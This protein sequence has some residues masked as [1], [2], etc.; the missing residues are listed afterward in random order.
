[1]VNTKFGELPKEA[2][3]GVYMK[4][5]TVEQGELVVSVQ[6]ALFMI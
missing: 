4:I 2:V 5:H 6:R 3:V 1:M